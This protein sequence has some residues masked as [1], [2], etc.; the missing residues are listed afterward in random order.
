VSWSSLP[1]IPDHLLSRTVTIKRL[2]SGSWTAI[3][4]DAACSELQATQDPGYA[5]LPQFFMRD[6]GVDVKPGDLCLFNGDDKEY[7]VE[8]V[9]TY[10]GHHHE[11]VVR[12][13]GKV[14]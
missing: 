9:E 3:I 8:V 10:A 11:I 7:R 12:D 5:P 14:T 1:A 4:A 2:V 13:T 6:S